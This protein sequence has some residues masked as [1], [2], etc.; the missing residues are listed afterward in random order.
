M[1]T[2]KTAAKVGGVTLVILAAIGLAG[3]YL[4]KD[5]SGKE[6]IASPS[7]SGNSK[8][9]Q[10]SKASQA[11]IDSVQSGA[12]SNQG[13]TINTGP[14]SKNEMNSADHGST[15]IVNNAPKVDS[16][17]KADLQVVTV[18][19][20]RNIFYKE[21]PGNARETEDLGSSSVLDIL[22]H[23]KGTGLTVLS[24]LRLKCLEYSESEAEYGGDDVL[25]S[26]A[27]YKVDLSTLIKPGS[28]VAVPVSHKINADEAERFWV[29]LADPRRNNTSGRKLSKW[30]FQATL[31]T[32][33]G[34]LRLPDVTVRIPENGP[35]INT[36]PKAP[37]GLA[38]AGETAISEPAPGK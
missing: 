11:A 34:E 22:L 14:D 2:K 9:A 29:V 17:K 15:L 37:Q 12:Q 13:G 26:T 23:N 19:T 36:E 21:L 18:R 20:A 30:R 7:A 16:P 28:E 38:S 4:L 27:T 35:P 1:A 32:D 6:A 24:E 3:K 10:P 33:S 25:S 5:G 31:V 8:V